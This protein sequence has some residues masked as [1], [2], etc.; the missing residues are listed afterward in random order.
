MLALA[1]ST[2]GHDEVASKVHLEHGFGE[3]GRR[4]LLDV[5][6]LVRNHCGTERQFGDRTQRERRKATTYEHCER[7]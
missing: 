5:I 1:S 2:V 3:D 7:R 4:A 6:L